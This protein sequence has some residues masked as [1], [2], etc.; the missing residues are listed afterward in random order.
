MYDDVGSHD[1]LGEAAFVSFGSASNTAACSLLVATDEEAISSLCQ[2]PA[3]ARSHLHLNRKGWD[4]RAGR[5]ADIYTIAILAR[6]ISSLC[7]VPF[8]VASGFRKQHCIHFPT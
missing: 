1:E 4:P 3:I 7:Q 5:D 6:R 8:D 2:L